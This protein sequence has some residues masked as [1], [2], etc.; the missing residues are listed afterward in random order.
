M[1]K[2]P[3]KDNRQ[4]ENRRIKS[5]DRLAELE[6]FEQEILPALKRD[7]KAGLTADELRKKYAAYAQAR[8]IT[9]IMIDP[10]SSKAT[11][12]AKDILD[13]TEG[14]PKETKEVT[15]RLQNL[16][17]EELDAILK[18]EMEDIQTKDKVK[19]N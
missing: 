7:L 16:P 6:A 4:T 9:T 11:A 14:K 2:K 17:E 5:L 3:R 15:H 8:L 12:A 19:L 13:R 1:G 10:D 18:S